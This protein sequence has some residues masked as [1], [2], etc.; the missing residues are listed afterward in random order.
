MQK[1]VGHSDI[2]TTLNIY[3]QTNQKQQDKTMNHMSDVFF[4]QGIPT[5][6]RDF[7]R[8]LMI[9][10]QKKSRCILMQKKTGKPYFQAFRRPCQLGKVHRTF[11]AH[12][13]GKE[14]MRQDLNLRPLRPERSALPN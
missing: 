12:P 6:I 9:F 10:W 11:P 3:A 8:D 7:I 14:S 2:K 5:T 13:W 4:R 1:W